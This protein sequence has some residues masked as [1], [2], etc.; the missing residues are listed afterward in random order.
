MKPISRR[1]FCQAALATGALLSAPGISL[2]ADSSKRKMTIDLRWGSIGVRANQHQAIELAAKHGFESIEA[3]TGDLTRIPAGDRKKFL[4]T[5][6]EKGLVLSAAGF[7]VNLVGNE[8]QYQGGLKTLPEVL[9][10]LREFGV[11]R[12]GTWIM[13]WHEKLT[14]RQSFKRY[15]KRLK[16]VGPILKDHNVRLGLEYIGTKHLWTRTRH[17]FVHTMAETKELLGEAGQS[18]VGFIL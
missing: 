2:A 1:N 8:S 9:K 11:T 7:P 3:R 14:Y 18:S 12:V 17:S 6:K 15:V 4:E 13:P 16:E 10:L 5:L